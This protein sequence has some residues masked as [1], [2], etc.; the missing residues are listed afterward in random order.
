M[1]AT[2]STDRRAF[3]WEE[4]RAGAGLAAP[5]H[6]HPIAQ[7]NDRAGELRVGKDRARER[8]DALGLT[9][10]D[11][12]VDHPSAPEHVVGQE[13]ASRLEPLL[14]YRQ[15]GGVAVLVDVAEDDVE[16]TLGLAQRRHRL[17][18]VEAQQGGEPEAL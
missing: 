16:L 9:V 13:Q 4:R 15:R 8:A 3:P 7:R 1:R 18:H 17:A 6:E 11:A 2:R 12:A 10:L 5:G 14:D